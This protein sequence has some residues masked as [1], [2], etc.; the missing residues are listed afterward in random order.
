[1]PD[2][3]EA[4]FHE[5]VTEPGPPP[6]PEGGGGGRELLL[7][8]PPAEAFALKGC[9]LAGDRAIENGHVVIGEGNVIQA[10]SAKAPAGV[11]VHDT[12]GV[13]CPGLIDLHGHP[14][15]NVFAAWEPPRQFDN[16]YQWRGSDIY[17]RLVRDPQNVLLDALSS[18]K[19][20]LRY[21][22][23]RALVGGVTAIQGTGGQ[24]SQYQAEA[25]VR[26]VDKWILGGQVARAMIDLPA[27]S[28]RDM[29]RLEK[30][31]GEIGDGTVKAFYLHLA[32]G[33]SDNE[34]SRDEFGKLVDLDGL[35]A[36]TVLIHATALNPDQLG[37][38][39]DAG[40]KI[41]WSPQSNLRLYGETTKAAEA[42]K[43]GVPVGL[44]ADWLPSGSTSL[45]AELKVARRALAEQG[46]AATG[47][48][49]V[50]MVTR[51]AAA[52]AGLGDKLGELAPQR[53]ADLVVFER[54]EAD[55]WE[56]VA[57]ADPSWVELV[58]L[59][60]DLAYG[61]ADWLTTLARPEDRA[62]LEPLI[63]WGKQML[64]DT[65]HQAKPADDERPPTLAALRA[66]LI[67]HFPQV[68]PIFA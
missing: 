14:E 25:L 51:D 45:L 15:F 12:G 62:E 61:R 17:H 56:N 58:V 55:P 52:I 5:G 60:G 10:V 39:K 32:E 6:A 20:E 8:A 18:P 22:E 47:R 29:P 42:I 21:A 43:R 13:I 16:R 7:R 31:L 59:D 9:V 27:P 46:L 63:A 65:R 28:S 49:L 19:T 44:G 23:V 35:T 33:R 40:A 48:Q 11:P 50:D 4:A 3:F 53:P 30:I 66:D 38:V 54:G 24:A 34:R 68:G 1:V 67:D 41:V 36:A 64:L 57:K 26:N 37:D 2:R